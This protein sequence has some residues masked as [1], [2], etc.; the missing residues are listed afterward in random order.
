MTSCTSA[1]RAAAMPATAALVEILRS[2]GIA[3]VVSG[4]G[5][6]VLALMVAGSRPSAADVSRIAG[7]AGPVWRVLPLRVDG[8]GAQVLPS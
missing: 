7:E 8:D 2:A 6:S 4:A 1:Y 3:A 5:P